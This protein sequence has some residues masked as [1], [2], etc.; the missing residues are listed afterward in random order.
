[1]EDLEYKEAL[2]DYVSTNKKIKCKLIIW[3]R[4]RDWLWVVSSGEEAVDVSFKKGEV[5]EVIDLAETMVA[6]QAYIKVKT[7]KNPRNTHYQQRILAGGI[8]A[9]PVKIV[10]SIPSPIIKE[11][12]I[13]SILYL[14]ASRLEG[15]VRASTIKDLYWKY[16]SRDLQQKGDRDVSREVRPPKTL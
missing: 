13:L 8:G 15:E 1:M 9:I 2:E 7:G 5:F 14:L 16:I 10:K 12:Q 11:E 6:D 4:V 3:S